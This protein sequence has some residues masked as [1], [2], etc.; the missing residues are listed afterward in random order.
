MQKY[1]LG[2]Y[3]KHALKVKIILIEDKEIEVIVTHFGLAKTER[4]E[5]VKMLVKIIKERTRP[6]IIMGDFNV[7][8]G[9][10]N[11]AYNRIDEI[12]ELYELMTDTFCAH[13]DQEATTFPSRFDLSA[14]ADKEINGGKGIRID[15][16][17]VSDEFKVDKA[18]IPQSRASD[19]LPYYVELTLD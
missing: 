18:E 4:A 12:K 2:K 14:L 7:W 11:P 8:G 17:F 3:I 13:P 1:N 15:Y 10:V 5:S 9:A 6:L 16:I 19:H